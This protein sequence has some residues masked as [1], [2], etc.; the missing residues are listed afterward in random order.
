LRVS[1]YL[2][3]LI[4]N[5]YR[6]TSLITARENSLGNVGVSNRGTL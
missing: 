2:I 4:A 1:A 3:T 5:K 6:P